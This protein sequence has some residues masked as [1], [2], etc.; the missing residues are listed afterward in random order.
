MGDNIDTKEITQSKE[1]LQI[2][3]E[4]SNGSFKQIL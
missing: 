1:F 2:I 3:A 4:E